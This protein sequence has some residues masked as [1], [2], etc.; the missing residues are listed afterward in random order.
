MNMLNCLGFPLTPICRFHKYPLA[1]T[2]WGQAGQLLVTVDAQSLGFLMVTLTTL[3]TSYFLFLSPL[4]ANA[5]QSNGPCG[6]K[7]VLLLL[8]EKKGTVSLFMSDHVLLCALPHKG[9]GYISVY[10]IEINT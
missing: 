6:P 7:I 10:G 2:V 8:L 5:V 9:E 4:C 1:T 3:I